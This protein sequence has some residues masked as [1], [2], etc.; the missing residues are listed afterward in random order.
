MNK[1]IKK[2]LTLLLSIVIFSAFFIDINEVNASA[3]SIPT[4]SYIAMIKNQGWSNWGNNGE[5]AGTTGQSKALTELGIYVGENYN[6]EIH[7]RVYSSGK[8][9]DW[10]NGGHS[11]RSVD[12]VG[13][14]TNDIQAVQVKLTGELSQKYD[15]V[16]RVHS[17]WYGWLD[18]VRN[19]QTAG[20]YEEGRRIEAIEVKLVEKA[21]VRAV[22]IG[23]FNIR[24]EI[25]MADFFG[26][27]GFDRFILSNS[28]KYHILNHITNLP[29]KENDITY[30]YMS[31]HGG[32]DGGVG[33]ASD[34]YAS[35]N[36]LKNILDNKP[37]TFVLMFDSCYSGK[38]VEDNIFNTPGSLKSS[39]KYKIITACNGSQ[40]SGANDISTA[41]DFWTYG[42]GYSYYK[43]GHFPGDI[44][45]LESRANQWWERPMYWLPA[46][47]NKDG[48][49][50]LNELTK[51]SNNRK[52]N[53]IICSYPANSD[54]VMFE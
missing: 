28:S 42:C 13:D 22:S 51:Y 16:Y 29:T 50:T 6:K 23:N 34:W 10:G 47:A 52:N 44:G 18:W 30:I 19:G 43:A 39:S 36:E 12:Y 31:C 7:Y 46:D 33:M 11:D 41:T 24:D 27:K 48:H 9:S 37:G 32:Q 26:Y 35:P 49:V 4:I 40:N 17:E 2:A 20:R 5:T 53:Q 25:F 21:K 54:F 38:S 14:Y 3:E 8:W 15:V 45:T 1:I